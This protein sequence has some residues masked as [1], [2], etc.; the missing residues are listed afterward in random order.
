MGVTST[1]GFRFK[2]VANGVQL[3]LFQ[4]ETI[5]L[6]DN[7]TGLF[8]LGILPA[9]FTRQMTLPG[10]QKNNNFF[11]FV[12]DISVES[13]MTFSTNQKVN[14]YLDFDGIYLS[15]G[16]LQ[17]NKVNVR[18]NKFIDSYEVTIYGGLA[19][20]GRDLKRAFLTDLTGSLSQFN[21]TASYANIATSWNGN[22]FSGSIVY[23]MAEYGQKISYSPEEPYFGIDSTEG[24]MCV[25]DYKPAIRVM[26]VWNAIFEQYGY[27]YTSEFLQQGWLDGVYMLCNYGLRYP[28]F[29]DIDLET[30]GLFKIAP[31]SGSGQ[32]DVILSNGSVLQ[33][34][35]YNILENPGGNM[36]SNL[37]YSLDFDSKLR[38][39]INL[40]FQVSSSAAGNG[41]P[42]FSLVIK[43][44]YGA[45]ASSTPLYNINSYMDEIQTYNATQTKTQTFNLLT[46]WSSD[47]L[48]SGSY[49]FN[50]VYIAQGGNNFRVT[51]DPDNTPK[52]YLSVTK[53]N[54][55]ADGRIMKI[56]QNMPYGTS[57]I[58]LIDFITSIQ[59]K[60]NL[61]MYPNKTKLNDFI[62]E[63]FITWYKDGV[64]RDFNKYINLDA[65]FDVTPAN[66]LAVQNLNFGDALDQDYVSQQ[67]AKGAN[68]EYGKAYYVDTENFFS[69]GDFTVKTTL[70]SSPLVYL[71]GTGVSGS[72]QSGGTIATEVG[73]CQLSNDI[74]YYD[75]C[76]FGTQRNIFS[77]TGIIEPSAV[78]YYD[79]YGIDRVSGYKYI[80]DNP[81]TCNIFELNI[82]TGVVLNDTG[83]PCS[84]YGGCI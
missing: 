28:I 37:V 69:Q 5:F 47:L 67:F 24:A 17:L 1:Q 18:A 80:V 7:I 21:H 46:Q 72:E 38:G 6:S 34:P 4:D 16:Y 23:P 15:A 77:S 66:N 71:A 74:N 63:P 65:P 42:Q 44:Q 58:K 78:L 68:R 36:S 73:F 27:T 32:T 40:N 59:K 41:I 26:E 62:V 70:A 56:G 14:C 76:Q 12:Y 54:Q 75:V 9:D 35:W 25:E 33:L 22:L 49:Y 60:F 3:D 53:V 29:D 31:V 39:D 82:S 19:S 20:F 64:I 2:I 79:A 52:S 50:I 8:D 43:N 61:V 81:S 45:V 30:Y 51:L 48:P 11:E 55:G 10:T 83:A 57:G 13:P 84:S